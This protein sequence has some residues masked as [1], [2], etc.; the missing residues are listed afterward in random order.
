MDDRLE[1]QGQLRPAVLK[2]IH[3]GHPG[4]DAMID[5]S[6]YLWWPHMQKD[7]V[8]LVEEC[9]ECTIYDMNAQSIIP[10]NSLKPPPLISQ[11]AKEVL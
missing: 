8:N 2:R 1:V 6:N 11:P 7:I 10:K 4:Q 5:V 3:R 9:R